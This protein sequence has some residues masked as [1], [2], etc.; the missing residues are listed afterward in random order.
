[1]IYS[2]NNI[3][4]QEYIYICTYIYIYICRHKH[5]YIVYL[6]ISANVT[7]HTNLENISTSIEKSLVAI[8]C[9]VNIGVLTE[10]V[11]V[12]KTAGLP[13]AFTITGW[14]SSGHICFRFQTY[15]DVFVYKHF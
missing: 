8:C 4:I 1:M 14:S 7:F 9:A 11:V 12:M 3:I 10:P 6:Y 15:S 5:K 2:Y 13:V